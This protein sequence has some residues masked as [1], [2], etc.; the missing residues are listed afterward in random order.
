MQSN[1]N[2]FS[3]GVKKDNLNLHTQD[4]LATFLSKMYLI[5]QRKFIIDLIQNDFLDYDKSDIDLYESFVK[6]VLSEKRPIFL[7]KENEYRIRY[8]Y[9]D[10][11][12]LV[13]FINFGVMHPPYDA[14]KLFYWEHM[15]CAR[16]VGFF[17]YK[18]NN[19]ESN[20]VRLIVPN[21]QAYVY[22]FEKMYEWY[23]NFHG[24]EDKNW[25][26]KISYIIKF[27]KNKD[28]ANWCKSI[29]DKFIGEHFT[30]AYLYV[31]Y[32]I[33]CRFDYKNKSISVYVP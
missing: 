2:V 1:G 18:P 16:N 22:V 23:V 19:D 29:Y 12:V 24:E 20:R 31:L 10:G 25:R 13:S 8:T 14:G 33:C 26:E 15:V 6:N 4:Y 7:H 28:I 3:D 5:V 32:N 9:E 17:Y 21:N 30:E 27:V 11:G